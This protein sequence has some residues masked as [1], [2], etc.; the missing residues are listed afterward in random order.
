VTGVR[1][2]PSGSVPN[3]FRVLYD[4]H[5]QLVRGMLKRLGMSGQDLTDLTQDVFLVAFKN[6]P[7]FEGRSALSTWLCGIC[8]RIVR[9]YR[10]SKAHWREVATD[11]DVLAESLADFEGASPGLI[12][13]QQPEAERLLR[14]LS[15]AQRTVF[16]LFEVHELGGP[17][18]ARLLELPEGTVHSRLRSA[19]ARLR[20]VIRQTGHRWLVRTLP[21]GRTRRP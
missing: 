14:N 17:E 9:G 15:H 18:I 8:I 6:L 10:R 20:R 13:A 1:F 4:T 11:P 2:V 12:R 19:R 21:C 3:D 16:I 7:G 5:L